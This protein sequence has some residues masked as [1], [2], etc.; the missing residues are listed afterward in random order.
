LARASTVVRSSL[1]NAPSACAADSA[2]RTMRVASLIGA[3][4]DVPTTG[5]GGIEPGAPPAFN[6]RPTCESG[7]GRVESG[8]TGGDLPLAAA[9]NVSKMPQATPAAV[10][11]AAGCESNALPAL[12][13]TPS[14][15]GRAGDVRRAR[16]ASRR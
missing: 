9:C 5:S 6:R 10:I 12:P 2:S 15:A 8:A 13:C 4:T 7:S 11:S 14:P 3:A 1:L 16:P